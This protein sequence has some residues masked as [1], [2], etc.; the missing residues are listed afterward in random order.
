MTLKRAAQTCAMPRFLDV[1]CAVASAAL[2]G[3][4]LYKTQS[5]TKEVF[6]PI[7]AA[8]TG[9][10]SSYELVA[11]EQLLGGPFVCM[12][13]QFVYRLVTNAPAGFITWMATI[14]TFLPVGILINVEGG[15][16]GAKGPV[17]YPT[18][19]GFISILL[20]VS[21]SVPLVWVPSFLL[22]G[23]SRGGAVLPKRANGSLYLAV[24]VAILSILAF[25]VDVSTYQ[26]TLIAGLVG[27]PLPVMS[28]LLLWGM[29]PK[30]GEVLNPKQVAQGAIATSNA[31]A[32]SS[33]VAFAF[34]MA[35][36]KV[37][38]NEFG[39]DTIA[40]WNALWTDADP[41]V[42]FMTID[43]IVLYLGTVLYISAVDPIDGFVTLIATPLLGPGAAC[44][45]MFWG[46]ERVRL[47]KATAVMQQLEHKK[48][49]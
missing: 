19:I 44:G 2:G 7:L 5:V 38:Y 42:Q 21:V 4:A 32:V 33:L 30:V 37:A 25:T 29:E 14:A 41:C 17:R 23:G 26:W 36:L 46:H 13:S 1:A 45:L 3:W 15:R 11:Y 18:I 48:A 6:E 9:K 24:P 43:A 12:I 10:E 28:T 49:S 20:A 35:I 22:L 47:A 40:L 31:F 27:G 16:S 34:W 8:C 39:F